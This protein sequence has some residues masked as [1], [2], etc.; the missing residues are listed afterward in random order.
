VELQDGTFEN[1]LFEVTAPKTEKGYISF[2]RSP[3]NN[4]IIK[5]KIYNRDQLKRTELRSRDVQIKGSL[6]DYL[7]E[8]YPKFFL[9][10]NILCL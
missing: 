6:E 4:Y 5:H 2:I 8:K 10:R 9:L 7:K 1:Y 3:N